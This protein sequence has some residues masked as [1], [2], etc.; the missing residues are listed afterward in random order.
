MIVGGGASGYAAADTLRSLGFTGR[1]SILSSEPYPPIDRTRL[2][3]ALITDAAKLLLRTPENLN[4]LGIELKHS[5]VT[6]V[7]TDARSVT[8]E[9]GETIGYDKLVLATGGSPRTLPLPGFR[10][11]KGI[12]KLRT[13]PETKDIVDAMSGGKKRVV[14]VGTGFIGMEIA[15]ALYK[16]HDINIIGMEKVPLY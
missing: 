10:E 1:V 13:V 16:D 8:T 3:K 14:I 2:S 4:D 11:L 5:K 6:K 15:I 7:D 12:Y 9:H